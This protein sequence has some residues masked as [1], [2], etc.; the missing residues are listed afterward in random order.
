MLLWR[1]RRCNEEKEFIRYFG[2][3]LIEKQI[4]VEEGGWYI[5]S[6]QRDV[7]PGY[8]IVALTAVRATI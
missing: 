2:I 8:R 7:F 1:R 5:R 6:Q 3:W 4:R